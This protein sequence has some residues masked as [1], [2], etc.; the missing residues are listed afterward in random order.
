MEHSHRDRGAHHCC[1][2]FGCWRGDTGN[3]AHSYGELDVRP[4]SPSSENRTSFSVFHFMNFFRLH[5]TN[6]DVIQVEGLLSR[7]FQYHGT[8]LQCTPSP[9]GKSCPMAFQPQQLLLVHDW[10]VSFWLCFGNI[11]SFWRLRQDHVA[12]FI[13]GSV[14]LVCAPCH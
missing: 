13:P 14:L 7:A 6:F 10:S 12:F 3:E 4:P 9:P 1:L 2:C 5:L 8:N 11:T